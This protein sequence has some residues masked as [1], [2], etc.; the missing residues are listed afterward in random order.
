MPT[1]PELGLQQV[2]ICLRLWRR[3]ETAISLL[4][5]VSADIQYDIQVDPALPDLSMGLAGSRCR[6]AAASAGS[7][8][9]ATAPQAVLVGP[10]RGRR[11]LRLGPR[12]RSLR[13]LG[14]A[15]ASSRTTWRWRRR[16][17]CSGTW[18]KQVCIKFAPFMLEGVL[19]LH[20]VRLGFFGFAPCL[21]Q[22]KVFFK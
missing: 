13:R 1:G 10:R 22:E 11:S 21:T 3:S 5:I 9:R 19:G 14:S 8:Q 15:A 20:H 6:S 4:R 17:S 7:R 18:T 2:S 16:W 12:R